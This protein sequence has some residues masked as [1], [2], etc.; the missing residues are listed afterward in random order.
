MV[1]NMWVQ[2]S[3]LGRRTRLNPPA[4]L[5]SRC[6]VRR[7][8]G[9]LDDVGEGSRPLRVLYYIQVT[10]VCLFWVLV[11]SGPRPVRVALTEQRGL[12][13]MHA[14]LASACSRAGQD[15]RGF[16]DHRGSTLELA[17]VVAY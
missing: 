5:G 12:L 6:D 7:E 3:S 17:L 13:M 8:P 16:T 2:L 10:A 9:W 1:A 15:A 4:Q 11:G 14:L